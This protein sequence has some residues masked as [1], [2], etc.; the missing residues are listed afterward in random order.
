MTTKHHETIRRTHKEY[1]TR[2]DKGNQTEDAMNPNHLKKSVTKSSERKKL[3]ENNT[4]NGT[5]SKSDEATGAGNETNNTKTIKKKTDSHR[6]SRNKLDKKTAN[7]TTHLGAIM[8]E[9]QQDDDAGI[10]RTQ[11]GTLSPYQ[12]N[13]GHSSSNQPDHESKRKAAPGLYYHIKIKDKT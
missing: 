10:T 2:K 12:K 11:D 1:G 5:R 8:T 4:T 13:R 6:K 3:D 9:D 7:K